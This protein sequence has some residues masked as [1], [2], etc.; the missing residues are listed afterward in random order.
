MKHTSLCL[1]LL[2]SLYFATSLLRF[3][4]VHDDLTQMQTL[5]RL[6]DVLAWR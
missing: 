1:L 2:A 3:A 4:W 5:K 6:P